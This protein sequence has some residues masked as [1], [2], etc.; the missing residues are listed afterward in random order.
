MSNIDKNKLK[1][2]WMLNSMQWGG[3]SEV[4]ELA[5]NDLCERYEHKNRHYHTLQHVSTM[6]NLTVQYQDV[7]QS[8]FKS[9]SRDAIYFATWFHDAIQSTGKDNEKQSSLLAEKVL[10]KLNLP[11]EIIQQVKQ[12]ILATENHSIK[13]DN[14]SNFFIDLDLAIL[15]SDEDTYLSY[16][17]NCRKEYSV[18]GW[19]YKKGRTKFLRSMLDVKHI[20]QTSLFRE[21]FEKRAVR[22]INQELASYL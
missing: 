2:N 5:F 7:I 17:N 1:E 11:E 19:L 14:D 22:N 12:L 21:Q 20:F 3:N 16:M 9:Q 8:Q 13:S 4:A 15:A 6:L 10:T 18:P